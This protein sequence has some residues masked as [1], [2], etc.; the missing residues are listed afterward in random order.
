MLCDSSEL[1]LLHEIHDL[2]GAGVVVR[3]LIRGQSANPDH[4]SQQ[5]DVAGT[6]LKGGAALPG[7][8][9][10]LG[11]DLTISSHHQ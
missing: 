10:L 1:L 5:P 3:D 11:L 7:L 4:V 9:R 2:E 8:G 6:P